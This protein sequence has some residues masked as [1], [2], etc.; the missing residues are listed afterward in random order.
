MSVSA[1]DV[2][3]TVPLFAGLSRRQ[4]R[5]LVKHTEVDRYE[6]GALIVKEG[7]RTTTLF[8]V[9]EGSAKVRRGGR[10]ISHRGPGEFFGEISM[11]DGRPRAASVIAETAMQCVVVPKDSVRRLVISEPRVAWSLLESLATRLRG[12]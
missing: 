7:G 11:I 9:L 1:L 8:V 2:L 3:S 5:K 4:L 10:T 12:E 6:P